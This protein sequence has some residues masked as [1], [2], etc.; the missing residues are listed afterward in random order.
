MDYAKME[1]RE[2]WLR[3]PVLGDPS[4]DAFEKLGE[5]VH[6][7]EAPYEWAVNG[8][9]FR[10]PKTG[11][12]YY[13][14]GLYPYGYVW[15]GEAPEVQSHFL[16]YR[17]ADKGKSWECLGPGFPDFDCR[18]PGLEDTRMGF[19]DVVMTYDGEADRYWLTYDW[20]ARHI[21]RDEGCAGVGGKPRGP[22]P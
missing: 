21:D 14:A 15:S 7:S 3:H 19:P 1:R 9:I 8:S 20:G 12:W 22:V 16:I 10:D 18:F 17:S 13:Y 2:A 4:F 6:V 5:T 11:W